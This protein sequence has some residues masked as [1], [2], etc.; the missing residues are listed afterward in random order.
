MA[1]LLALGL[2][3]VL[4]SPAEAVVSRD[5]SLRVAVGIPAVQ[6]EVAKLRPVEAVARLQGDQYIVQLGSH[7]VV[8][9][10]VDVDAFS[11]KPV[12]VFTG[13]K[14]E[15][16]LARGPDTSFATRKLNAV[17][18]WVPLTLIFV[19]AFFDRRRPWR[20]LHF[21]L[22]AIAALSIS[23]AFWMRGNLDASVPL[24]YP[25]LVYVVAR[26]LLT[27]FRPRARGGVVTWLPVRGVIALT[28]GLLALR[29]GLTLADTFVSDIGYASAAGADRIAHGLE[30]YT[31][32]GNHFDTYGPLAYVLYIPFELVWPFHE[33]QLYPPAAQ[34]AA[35]AWELITVAGLVVL[36]RQLR[37]GWTL[38]LA[39]TAC[40]FTAL[41]LVCAS[42]D[43]LVAALVVWALVALRSTVVSGALAGAAAAAKIAPGFIVPLLARGTGSMRIGRAALYIAAA[44]TVCVVSLVPLLPDGG[45]REFYDT[46]IGFQLHRKSPFSIWSQ[47]PSLTWLQT[48][49]KTTALALP[50]VLVLVPRGPRS[51]GQ[52]AALSAAVLVAAEIPLQHWFYLYVPWFLALYCLALFSEHEADGRSAA[53]QP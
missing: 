50:L 52:M 47:H 36:G 26:M 7:G 46:T 38:A 31:R 49:L 35:I 33:N 12:K 4:A 37:L 10:E 15:F 25:T 34:A 8:H 6:R 30:L 32:G 13:T 21:D 45:V 22:A 20:L 14:A 44:V 19:G 17:W 41:S 29:V 53:S 18:L 9:A 2:S 40:P 3:L 11:G 43:G 1:A 27:G 28:L 51:V 23:Y 39:W 24:V 48:V 5:D 42:N 16:P